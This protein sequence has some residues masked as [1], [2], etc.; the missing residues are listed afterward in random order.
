MTSQSLMIAPAIATGF[1]RH[2]GRGRPMKPLHRPLATL[3][4]LCW[5]TRN[6]SEHRAAHGNPEIRADA[7]KQTMERQMLTGEPSY[8][9]FLMTNRGLRRTP[10]PF[11]QAAGGPPELPRAVRVTRASVRFATNVAYAACRIERDPSHVV[12]PL[13]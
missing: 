13:W 5:A 12:S 3:L 6:S 8:F 4:V 11:A 2:A 10:V 1:S 7:R 9:N